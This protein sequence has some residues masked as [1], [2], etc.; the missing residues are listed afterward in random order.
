MAEFGT[1]GRGSGHVPTVRSCMFSTLRWPMQPVPTP[2]AGL[3][4]GHHGIPVADTERCWQIGQVCT[5]P[6]CMD[7]YVDICNTGP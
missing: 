2:A 1:A 5:R 4:A 7:V 6:H 3:P